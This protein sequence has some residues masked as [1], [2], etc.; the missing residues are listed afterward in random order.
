MIH[1]LKS[2]VLNNKRER[3]DSSS[4]D[5]TPN[6]KRHVTIIGKE[7]FS[8]NIP[9][10]NDSTE[11]ISAPTCNTSF[12]TFMDSTLCRIRSCSKDF[13]RRLTR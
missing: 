6:P 7:P 12:E 4:S 8:E 11:D 9:E 3:G 10:L 13:L 5:N 2:L 1:S